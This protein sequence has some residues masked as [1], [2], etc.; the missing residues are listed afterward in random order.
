M[1]RVQYA[2][3]IAVADPQRLSHGLRRLLQSDPG[4]VRRHEDCRYRKFGSCY[5]SAAVFEA[6]EIKDGQDGRFGCL[7]RKT[8]A[9]S[10]RDLLR[11]PAAD[12]L[13]DDG[14]L[15]DEFGDGPTI[16]SGPAAVQG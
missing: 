4:V 2:K 13:L 11:Q 9:P 15:L 6:L 12:S 14:R 1:R 3:G 7:R 16:W 8:G 10:L 5:T